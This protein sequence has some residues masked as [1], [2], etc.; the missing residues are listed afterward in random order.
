LPYWGVTS[1]ISNGGFF[2]SVVVSLSSAYAGGMIKSASDGNYWL[3][4]MSISSL[5]GSFLWGLGI[6]QGPSS[7]TYYVR[8]M[9]Y[10]T[11]SR[12]LHACV[13]NQA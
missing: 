4:I 3:S 12:S 1:S 10:E 7:Y 13:Y 2:T 11:T 6:N 9:Y 5:N 8:L